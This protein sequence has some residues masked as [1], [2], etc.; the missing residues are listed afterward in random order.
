MI[1]SGMALQI[2]QMDVQIHCESCTWLPHGESCNALKSI[3]YFPSLYPVVKYPLS[4]IVCFKGVMTHN[5]KHR[6]D[7]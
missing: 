7:R 2:T 1:N 4:E 6:T 5:T 3:N